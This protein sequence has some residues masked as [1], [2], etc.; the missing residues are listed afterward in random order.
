MKNIKWF[1]F[2]EM[3]EH[4]DIYYTHSVMEGDL[5]RSNLAMIISFSHFY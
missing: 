2:L 1:L 3:I 4:T 5:T